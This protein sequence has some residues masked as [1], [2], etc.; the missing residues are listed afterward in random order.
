MN[1]GE[2]EDTVKDCH[3]YHKRVREKFDA[4]GLGKE[5]S[6]LEDAACVKNHKENPRIHGNRQTL[7]LYCESNQQDLCWVD[8]VIMRKES[9][10]V[11]V[12]IEIEESNIGPAHICGKFLASALTSYYFDGITERCLDDVLFIQI[13]N[14]KKNTESEK[15]TNLVKKWKVIEEGI[16]KLL[17]LKDSNITK[18]RLFW[19]TG[20][21]G[22]DF[23]GLNGKPNLYQEVRDHLRKQPV[24]VDKVLERNS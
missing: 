8:M 14:R 7:P 23:K 13:V 12:I 11:G 4:E 18:Y 19:G 5:F 20:N 22:T 15:E 2:G 21:D 1:T 17:P 16:T 3:P 6:L 10:T 24:F 9:D